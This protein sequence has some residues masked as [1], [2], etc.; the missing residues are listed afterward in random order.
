MLAVRSDPH[1]ATTLSAAATLG[2]AT[3]AVTTSSLEMGEG[4][5]LSV[6]WDC[7]TPSRAL[8]PATALALS[9]LEGGSTPNSSRAELGTRLADEA[10][11]AESP[12]PARETLSTAAPPPTQSVTR[13]PTMYRLYSHASP[14][15]LCPR[16]APTSAF[17]ATLTPRGVKR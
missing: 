16:V 2:V 10:D 6:I 3:S 12:D 14:R 13:A 4:A 7:C 17:L 11:A 5:L 1:A 15:A 9:K 8:R